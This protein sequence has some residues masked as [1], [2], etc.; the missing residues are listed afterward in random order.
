MET[1]RIC[2]LGV[3][4]KTADSELKS[5]GKDDVFVNSQSALQYHIRRI[6]HSPGSTSSELPTLITG[7]LD[8]L[9]YVNYKDSMA[10]PDEKRRNSFRDY[11]KDK[12]F[13]FKG[14]KDPYYDTWKMQKNSEIIVRTPAQGNDTE[15]Y[16][17][18]PVFQSSNDTTDW[19]RINRIDLKRE[20]QSFSS[21]CKKLEENETIGFVEGFSEPFNS[22]FLI[23]KSGA[24]SEQNKYYAVGPFKKIEETEDGYRFL[25]D[26]LGSI[27]LDESTWN[28]IV[29]PEQFNP[30]IIYLEDQLY[31]KLFNRF[32]SKDIQLIKD[33]Q[34]I[35]VEERDIEEQ[36]KSKELI[37]IIPEKTDKSII[38][39][40]QYF[41]YKEDLFYDERDLENFH[42]AIKTGSLVILSGMSGTG[43]SRLVE[44]YAKALGLGDEQKL[45]IPVRPSWNDDSDLLGYVDLNRM[46]Y[47]PSET[48]FVETLRDAER[49]TDQLYLICF[50]EMNLAR[51]EHY[52]SQFLS[53]LEKPVGKDRE[54]RIYSDTLKG[55]YNAQEYPSKIKIGS[56]VIFI[57]TVNIDES[58]YHFSDKVL[59][60]SNVIQLKILDYSTAWK[61]VN[62]GAIQPPKWSKAEYDSLRKE[63]DEARFQERKTCLWSLHQKLQSINESFG[64]SP[65]VVRQIEKYICNY[66]VFDESQR[67]SIESEAF[68][69]QIV[70]RV[71]T[72]IRGSEEKLQDLFRT[73][74]GEGS[75]LDPIF[76]SYSN[77]SR[78][79]NS[80]HA[81]EQK[82]K[83]LKI[84]GYCV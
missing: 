79:D 34:Q 14:N 6:S 71:L 12:V 21:F 17:T 18:I 65:R 1:S 40:C 8:S 9:H 69:V 44:V 39:Y 29:Y 2:M 84:Y 57:G 20:A 3:L 23:W 30:T 43:K 51:V 37:E 25:Y 70:Q 64:I 11:C 60:R 54:L 27:E 31:S 47:R 46:V 77:L 42:A 22:P 74:T 58:T 38:D 45:I 24:P 59:D 66:P 80:K 4:A 10:E 26:Y 81:L 55:L 16:V 5:T 7:Y 61:K 75:V 19:E 33:E 49:N 36:T 82:K 13:V 52:F 83:D 68:D 56:N 67:D 78:F 63:P 41:A 53:I 72:K 15:S 48:R 73:E 76:A 50:D 28:A 62:Y 32:A 35:D